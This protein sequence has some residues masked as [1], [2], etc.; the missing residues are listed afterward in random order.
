M[1]KQCIFTVAENNPIAKDIQ[2]MVLLGDTGACTAPGQFVDL[3][4]EGM[5]LRR[6]LSMCEYDDKSITLVFRAL[7]QGTAAL[8]DYEPGREIDMLTGLG[9]GYSI[10]EAMRAPLIV[11]GGM[12]V[13]PM[14][15]QARL[16]SELG[17]APLMLL[18]FK[19]ADDVFYLDRFRALNGTAYVTTADG[20]VGRAGMIVDLLPEM[21]GRFDYFYCCGPEPMMHAVSDRCNTSGQMSFERRMGCGFGACMGC[22]CKTKYG[23]KR[24]CVDG[25]V[26]TK[27]EIIW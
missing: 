24:I 10:P 8:R 19:S 1:S 21:A 17:Y 26:L 13:A 5:Y 9:N 23:N 18:G 22:T 6:P 20:S 15:A 14:Y 27:E 3:S 7:G 16:L 11:G 25:P 12:G 4:I 2:R